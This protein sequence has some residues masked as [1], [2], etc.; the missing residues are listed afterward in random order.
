MKKCAKY[1]CLRSYEGS[2]HRGFC[3]RLYSVYYSTQQYTIAGSTKGYL[4]TFFPQYS[5]IFLHM[6]KYLCRPSENRPQPCIIPDGNAPRNLPSL[7]WSEEGQ[8]LHVN[9]DDILVRCPTNWATSPP[10]LQIYIIVS[11]AHTNLKILP[12]RYSSLRLQ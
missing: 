3:A 10:Q 1:K 2:R 7:P 12:L 4:V 6:V 8:I 9:R 5:E 11:G